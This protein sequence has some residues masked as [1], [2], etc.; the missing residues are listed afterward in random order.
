M[1]SLIKHI[2]L[3]FC[4]TCGISCSYS[5]NFTQQYYRDNEATVQSIKNRYKQLYDQRPFSLELKDKA[6]SHIGLEIHTD[7]VKYVYSFRTDETYLVDTLDKYGFDVKGISELITDMQKA[8]CTWITN[9][10][11]YEKQE[12]KY[13]VFISVRDKQL[14][15]FLK[16]EKYF[17][18][19]IF[20]EPQR[21]DERE[22]LLDN[23]DLKRNR[24]I[25]G[26]VFRKINDRVSYA[27]TGKYR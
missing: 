8:H 17:T 20:D 1:N 7:T 9:L 18:L 13:L 3:W 6:L 21:Y 14:T 11:Y 26:V 23:E 10:D 16:P 27:L 2:V 15:A 12:K 24:L 5:K 22:R 4:I 25:N 19:A